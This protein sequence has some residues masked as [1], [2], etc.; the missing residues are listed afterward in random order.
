M[1]QRLSRRSVLIA[2]GVGFGGDGV[3][4]EY[5]LETGDMRVEHLSHREMPQRIAAVDVGDILSRPS[6]WNK[7]RRPAKL[8]YGYGE[9][10]DGCGAA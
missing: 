3:A 9:A 8:T 1:N 6:F 7:A 2:G 10:E 5:R 4:R